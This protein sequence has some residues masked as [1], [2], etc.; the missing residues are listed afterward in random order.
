MITIFTHADCLKHEMGYGHPESPAR[1]EVIMRALQQAPW[2]KQIIWQEAPLATKAQLQRVHD[3]DYIEG[4][5]DASPDEGYL[6]LDPDA[7]MNPHTLSAALHA[8]G[9]QVAAVDAVF[10]KSSKR[11]SKV[12]CLVRPPGH[13]AEPSAAMG[14][15]F[16]NNVAVGVMHALSQHNCQRVAIID[17][18]V[19]HGNGTE[20]M[21]L[22]EPRVCFWSS[23]QHPFY[24]GTSL[25]GNPPN[26]H[27]CPL[28]AGTNGQVF[29]QKVDNELIPLLEA[30]KPECIFISAGF[31]AH[32]LDPLANLSFSADDYAYVTQEIC[33]IASKY[34]DGKVISTLEGGYHL[35][36]LPESVV[37]HL[38]A[39]LA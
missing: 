12:F 8:A 36:A 38:S 19:H 10:S 29:R 14:F 2:T 6:Q 11:T 9:A 37:A 1:L 22:N 13:H 30:F 17:F 20:A 25:Q 26:I 21:F 23:F 3:L 27:L 24:P 4:I 35:Q 28:E 18:D 33:K 16:F 7:L 31:D 15:C 34:A 5:F 39:M 32:F